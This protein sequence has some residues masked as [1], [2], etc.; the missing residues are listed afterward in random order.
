MK[1][2]VDAGKESY[3]LTFGEATGL[4]ASSTLLLTCCSEAVIISK[5]NKNCGKARIMMNSK[6]SMG[7]LGQKMY[8]SRAKQQSLVA[9]GIY[10]SSAYI[11]PELAIIMP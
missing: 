6:Y 11:K 8:K 3:G 5:I 9:F 1:G 2:I 10:Q 7:N 4:V